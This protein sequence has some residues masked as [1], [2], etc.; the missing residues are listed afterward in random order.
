MS[1]SR[2]VLFVRSQIN[3]GL[4]CRRNVK[5][6]EREYVEMSDQHYK[7]QGLIVRFR[8]LS[9]Y[10]FQ[11]SAEKNEWLPRKIKGESSICVLFNLQY[12]IFIQYF[13]M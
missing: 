11:F 12:K 10:L 3:S 13:I 7:S 2:A 6:P 9:L 5:I 4:R 1:L 8:F